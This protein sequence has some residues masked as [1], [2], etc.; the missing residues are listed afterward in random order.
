[1][2][3]GSKKTPLMDHPW[4]KN[5]LVVVGLLL[6]TA[7]FFWEILAKQGFFWGDFSLSMYPFRSFIAGSYA[8]GNVP[9]WN[10]YVFSGYP[11]VGD[12]ASAILYPFNIAL[13][14]FAHNGA[15]KFKYVEYQGIFHIFLAGLFMYCLMRSF[16]LDR[17]PSCISAFVFMFSGFLIAHMGHLGMVNGAV[18]LPLVFLFLNKALQEKRTI[19]SIPSGLFLAF[20]ISAGHP[21]VPLLIIFAIGLYTVYCGVFAYRDQGRFKE[22]LRPVV[23]LV[24]TLFIGFALNISQI[25]SVSEYFSQ[26]LVHRNSYAAS[27]AFSSQPRNLITLLVP[28][29]FGDQSPNVATGWGSWNYTEMA[30]YVGILPIL[31][32]LLGGLFKKNRAALFFSALAVVSI[33]LGF[34]GYTFLHVINWLLVPGFDQVRCPARFIFLFD[35][36]VAFLS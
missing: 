23:I 6:L 24:V 18:W 33:L 12:I 8:Q 11:F 31:L 1:M 2:N 25:L 13:S 4:S 20:S 10:P 28:F 21:Q 3:D 15:L 7:L 17:L 22:A 19:W 26:A 29:F 27:V 30:G 35:F 34:G 5:T 9:L 14:L 36:S 16:K 32:A